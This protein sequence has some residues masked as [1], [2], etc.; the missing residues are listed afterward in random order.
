MPQQGPTIRIGAKE[1]DVNRDFT[2]R[3]LLTVEE[4]GGQP[5]ARDDAFESFGVIAA[6]VFVIQKRDDPTLAWEGF[7]D[8]NI[9]DIVGGDEPDEAAK[10]AAKAKARPTKSV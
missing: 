4:L 10:P 3:E 6:F 1:Y 8:G 5:L 9:T 7:L 2:W